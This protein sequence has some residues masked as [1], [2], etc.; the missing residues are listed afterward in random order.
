MLLSAWI[1]AS[2]LFCREGV[3]QDTQPDLG[4]LS[5]WRLI[6]SDDYF[7]KFDRKL[8]EHCEAAPGP[9]VAHLNCCLVSSFFL[10][11]EKCAQ[12]WPTAEE[13][14]M[15]FRDTHFMVTLLSED[16]R[17]YY[18]TRVLEL[19]NISVGPIL[20][21]GTVHASLGPRWMFLQSCF[22]HGATSAKMSFLSKMS[23]SVTVWWILGSARH[24]LKL[25]VIERVAE[26][27]PE[28]P[29]A[30]VWLGSWKRAGLSD[31][32]ASAS[33]ALTDGR[34]ARNLPLPLHRLA[35]LRGPRVPG[36]FPQLP[37]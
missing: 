9:H 17:S 29:P 19:Q 18:T 24:K 4:L 28:P 25:K 7:R 31:N 1:Y 10:W 5:M 15:T 20:G 21:E 33:F 16:I 12:Y 13:R 11:Q 8:T 26:L 34:E 2:Q 14:E 23:S 27:T 32:E 35:W 30:R 6:F 36:V 22:D 3:V 37:L